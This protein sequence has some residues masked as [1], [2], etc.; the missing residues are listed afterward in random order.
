MS[1]IVIEKELG[2][3]P[4]IIESEVVDILV[5]NGVVKEHVLFLKPNRIAGSKTPDIQIDRDMKWEI[6]SI[7]KDG[8]YTL[9]H[10]LRLGLSQSKNLVIDIRK[11]GGRV[12]SKYSHRIDT[13]Y[14]KRK[15]WLGAIIVL[16]GHK[17]NE[18]LT[19]K[20]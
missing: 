2:A 7:T 14:H 20:K 15:S 1:K 3:T 11:L 9:E 17:A 13:E 5:L 16:K 18:I 8:K 19:L 10:S 4:T 12:Q 6:K